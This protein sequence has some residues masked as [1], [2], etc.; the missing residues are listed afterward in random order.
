MPRLAVN[1]VPFQPP[2]QPIGL[3]PGGPQQVGPQ[4]G[5]PG[6][7]GIQPGGMQPPVVQP[8]GGDPVVAEVQENGAGWPNF[9]PGHGQLRHLVQAHNLGSG[10]DWDIESAQGAAELASKSA[11]RIRDMVSG[12][13]AL[14]QYEQNVSAMVDRLLASHPDAADAIGPAYAELL[15]T[16]GVVRELRAT[17]ASGIKDGSNHAD[18]PRAALASIRK[19]LR[20]FRYETQQVL[21]SLGFAAGAQERG[22]HAMRAIQNF[23]TFGAKHHVSADEFRAIWAAEEAMFAAA[24]NF[25]YALSRIDPQ[26]GAPRQPPNM[27]LRDILPSALEFSHRT[28]DR[29]RA[30][31]DADSSSAGI[32]DI[33]GKIP[34]KGGSRTV[35]FK[36][37]AGALVGL[38]FP[39]SFAA[40]LR[41]GANFKLYAEVSVPTGGGPLTTTF[42]IGGGVEAKALLRGLPLSDV[43]SVKI[44]AGVEGYAEHFVTRTYA[45]VEDLILDARRNR[46]ALARTIFGYVGAGV[47]KLGSLIGNLGRRAFRWMG[48]RSD[49]IKQTAS[50]YLDLLKHSG[51]VGALDHFLSRRAN[52]M[53]VGERRG[54]LLTG[55]AGAQASGNVAGVVDLGAN[56]SIS[57]SIEVG[58]SSAAFVPAARTIR[59]S[60]DPRALLRAGPRGG[61]PAEL[62]VVTDFDSL[63]ESYEALV[64][65]ARER[66]PRTDTE[67]ADFANAV[68]TH[69]IAAEALHRDGILTREQADLL[70]AR[71]SDPGI[72]IPPDIYR[73]YL[74]DGAGATKPPKIRTTGQGEINYSALSLQTD[75]LVGGIVPNPFARAVA[76]GVAD[77]ARRNVGLAGQLRYTWS[78]E[79]P[80]NPG[81]D[82]R[83]WENT[84]KTTC[85]LS[86]SSTAPVRAILDHIARTKIQ[87]RTGNLP[88]TEVEGE[89]RE[90]MIKDL[91][92]TVLP[93]LLLAG[94]KEGAKAWLSKPENI[95]KL[96]KFVL[97]HIDIPLDLLA[98]VIDR[99]AE[100]PGK[101]V[102]DILTAFV[103]IR[104]TDAVWKTEKLQTLEWSYED[105]NLVQYSLY[106]DTTT[107][108][109]INIDPVG[110]GL[111]V[112]A[113]LSY[114][115]GESVRKQGMMVNPTLV[116]LLGKTEQYLFADTSARAPGNSEPFKSWIGNNLAAI[117]ETMQGIRNGTPEALEVKAKAIEIVA[118]DHAAVQEIE[119][120][121]RAVRDLPGDALPETRL[122]AY[123]HLLTTLT[124]VFRSPL[125]P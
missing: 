69:L 94:A 52:P 49:E 65:V 103:Y 102:D 97:D 119:T 90:A 48:R 105:G 56:A 125:L 92:L 117:E 67:W 39:G 99:L 114:T 116:S 79:T 96:V 44:D 84:V 38:G 45:T 6:Q 27:A 100:D 54:V 25:S 17:F 51:V 109:G 26:A 28:N 2:P 15:R 29:I 34:S 61:D 19:H 31:Q 9:E 123:R 11:K 59:A 73:E 8:G 66:N 98:A 33:L 53:V 115:V 111:G 3:E 101:F 32:R 107:K 122:E 30:F 113:N 42:R 36:I 23:F 64:A 41:A 35:E 18:D 43:A 40:G 77:V 78:R 37:G 83:P 1:G 57:R 82:P 50:E 112:S 10:R 7:P 118:N 121:W 55:T 60:A 91:A 24:G 70:L 87:A 89:I 80:A 4:Q 13:T 68:R 93:K 62:P 22:E 75:N 72:R 104:G 86:L 110:I 106:D 81:A 71:F 120:A 21:S 47:C 95:K 85:R 14:K 16:I 12:E 108:S 124:T 74:M 46:L 63:A 20:I 88:G 76:T 5:V 58:V